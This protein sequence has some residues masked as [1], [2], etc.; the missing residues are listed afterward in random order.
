MDASA[1]LKT[2]TAPALQGVSDRAAISAID[3]DCAAQR[4]VINDNANVELARIEREVRHFRSE[5][6]IS[7]N[8]FA[9]ATRNNGIRAQIAGAED[10]RA[11]TLNNQRRDLS[12]LGK[13]CADLRSAERNRQADRDAASAAAK[14]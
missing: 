4:R 11:D 1:A 5:M 14:P 2:G 12:A 7:A 10:R 9:G 3:G 6:N 13:S 8:N